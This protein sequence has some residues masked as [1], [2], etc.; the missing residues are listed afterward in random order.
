[1]IPLSLRKM[2]FTLSERHYSL[3]LENF[4]LSNMMKFCPLVTETPSLQGSEPQGRVDSW[5]ELPF[6]PEL[7][8]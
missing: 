2:P 3:G 8:R 6:R 7:E 1:S 5:P 4:S